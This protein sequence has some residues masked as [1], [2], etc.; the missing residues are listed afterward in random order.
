MTVVYQDAGSGR[1]Y[2]FV[3]EYN[4]ESDEVTV[5]TQGE[6]NGKYNPNWNGGEKWW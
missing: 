6:Y 2:R 5:M 3:I 4:T 1:A